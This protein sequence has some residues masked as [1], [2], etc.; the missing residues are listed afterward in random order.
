MG[1]REVLLRQGGEKGREG[2]GLK[3]RGG[4]AP[5]PNNLTSPMGPSKPRDYRDLPPLAE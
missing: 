1:K 5:K 2:K 4:L 3:R